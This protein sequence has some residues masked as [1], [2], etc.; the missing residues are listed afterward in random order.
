MYYS[1][2]IN[3]KPFDTVCEN[4]DIVNG[5]K[6]K[7]NVCMYQ[8][9]KMGDKPFL[10]YVLYKSPDT[11]E[12]IFPNTYS[13][14]KIVEIIK[15][16]V[17]CYNGSI[18]NKDFDLS[19]DDE[20]DN[21]MGAYVG[22]IKDEKDELDEYYV[23]YDISSLNIDSH[24]VYENDDIIGTD[25]YLV[26]IDEI[27]NITSSC[28]V[29]ISEDV[30]NLFINN[31]DLL[32]LKNVET[33]DII[34][35]PTIG[36]VIIPKNKSKYL[37]NFGISKTKYDESYIYNFT[38]DTK[39]IDDNS[40]GYYFTTKFM[41]PTTKE[42]EIIRFCIFLGNTK[43]IINENDEDNML[44]IENKDEYNDEFEYDSIYVNGCILILTKYMQQLPLTIH[45]NLVV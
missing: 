29:N 16:I 38:K 21:M 10:Q 35:T 33:G 8:I 32:Y 7:I 15:R 37:F 44:L 3:Y 24:I 42:E 22:Y 31:E 17:A 39:L 1:N 23:F 40:W 25:L 6:I 43:M 11:K 12:L 18:L 19:L 36:Y 34:E 14:N 2:S 13:F 27:I 41:K 9:N 5:N 26:T 4:N 28:G 45:K 20:F 30:I